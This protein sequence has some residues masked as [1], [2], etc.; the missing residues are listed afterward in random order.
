MEL[1]IS[2]NFIF[3][4]R[5]PEVTGRSGEVGEFPRVLSR[6]SSRA[7]P[8]KSAYWNR[9]WAEDI[10]F[11]VVK[12][13]RKNVRPRCVVIGR[14]QVKS[15]GSGQNADGVDWLPITINDTPK[16]PKRHVQLDGLKPNKQYKLKVRAENDLG[17]SPWSDEFIF[18][19]APG[20]RPTPAL[21]TLCIIP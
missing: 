15:E 18:R 10:I 13:I 8:E 4:Y 19:T 5:W 14:C 11:C 2:T 16:T 12:S 3:R 1:Q 7:S 21:H 9:I 6:T 20:N 17:W